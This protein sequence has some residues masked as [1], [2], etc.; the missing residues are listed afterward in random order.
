[1]RR[2]FSPRITHKENAS[3]PT[4]H[5]LSSLLLFNIKDAIFL[6]HRYH[7][8]NVGQR[9]PTLRIAT[10]LLSFAIIEW[11]RGINSNIIFHYKQHIIF[12]NDTGWFV[13]S[14]SSDNPLHS[15]SYSYNNNRQQVSRVF[16]LNRLQFISISTTSFS[17]SFFCFATAY[18]ATPLFAS[19]DMLFPHQRSCYMTWSYTITSPSVHILLLSPSPTAKNVCVA[20]GSYHYH[21]IHLHINTIL[22]YACIICLLPP[23]HT[24]IICHDHTITILWKYILSYIK[25]PLAITIK[26]AYQH[27]ILSSYSTQNS[28][29]Y[30]G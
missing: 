27:E 29:C 3:Q 5:S 26:E 13:I 10:T 19:H 16:T 20:R 1:M 8:S 2:L 6:H 9:L 21:L 30:W 25:Q 15:P 18:L 28:I 22:S 23:H 17:N 12:P 4:K 14:S 7:P 11:T 24:H